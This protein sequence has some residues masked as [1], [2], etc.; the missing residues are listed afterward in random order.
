MQSLKSV[1]MTTLTII[2]VAACSGSG[3]ATNAPAGPTAAVPSDAA[4]TPPTTEAPAATA[5]A[6][7]AA[8][9]VCGLLSPADLKSAIGKDY[10]AGVA[11]AYAGCAWNVGTSGVNQ[12]DL[13]Y[14]AIQDQRLDFIKS[15]FPGGV[16][17][18]VSGHAAYWNPA[19][20]LS[21]MWVDVGGR[22]FILSFPRSEDLTAEYQAIAQKLAEIAVAKL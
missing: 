8:V 13:V 12:G 6:S 19:Q 9:D 4:A 16:D 21:S 11:D 14:G 22:L 2:A 5:A 17:A 10:G 3:A 7:A 20:G 1:V 18:T 15:S